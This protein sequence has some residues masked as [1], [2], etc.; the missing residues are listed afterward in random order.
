MI[1]IRLLE[2]LAAFAEEGTLSAA[3]LKLHTSQPALTRSMKKLEDELGVSLFDRHKNRLEL[4]A[5]GKTAAE[6]AVNVLRE[7]RY[8]EER[9]HAYDRSL[10]TLSIGFCAPI[11]QEVLTP[12]INNVFD[13]M[14]VSSDMKDD[15]DFLAKLDSRTYQ[16]AVTHAVP[17]SD[18]FFW[19]KCGHEDLYIALAPSDPLT[20]YPELHL[21]DLEGRSVLLFTRIG[22]W[23]NYTTEKTQDIHYLLQ[24]DRPT[25]LELAS[26][27]GYPCFSSSYYIRRGHAVPGRI[28]V[29]LAD[30]ECHTDYYL[31]CLK[32]EQKR[33]SP[34]FSRI[35]E[36]TIL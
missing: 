32:E 26:N 23:K 9:V 8:F 29:R 11:P 18:R 1:E 15:A 36:D 13:G 16:L 6:Y 7:D 2:E 4:N 22:F 21:R 30:T 14:T 25:F 28:N 12:M 3:A 35:R 17:D 31:V 19:K 10:H 5:T 34:L 33:F 20:F 24:M 27:S